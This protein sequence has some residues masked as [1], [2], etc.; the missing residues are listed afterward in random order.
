MVVTPHGNS[1]SAMGTLT[2]TT[3]AL[4]IMFGWCVADSDFA[5]FFFFME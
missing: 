4:A 2:A 1:V 5:F 3:G